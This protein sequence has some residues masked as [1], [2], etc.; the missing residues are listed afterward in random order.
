[1]LD[2]EMRNLHLAPKKTTQLVSIYGSQM[3]PCTSSEDFKT[4]PELAL[5]EI[6]IQ[7]EIHGNTCFQYSRRTMV[8]N[9]QRKLLEHGIWEFLWE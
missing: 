8:I 3:R 9:M 7:Q 1:M 6:S 4:R 5:L 2:S